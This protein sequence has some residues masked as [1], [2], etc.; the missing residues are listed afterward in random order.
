MGMYHSPNLLILS[1]CSAPVP[2]VGSR[3]KREQKTPGAGDAAPRG[4]KTDLL[5]KSVKSSLNQARVLSSL[6]WGKH[7]ECLHLSLTYG[8]CWP[9]TKAALASEKSLLTMALGRKVECGMWCLEYQQRG[10]P[11]FHVL[12]WLNGRSLGEFTAW[13]A[14][15]W[16]CVSDNRSS[17]GV[18][19]TSG[20]QARGVWYLAMHAA[21]R[22]Q[23]P[24]YAV[25]RWWGYIQRKRLF[26]AQDVHRVADVEERERIWWAR[27]YR[28]ATGCKVRQSQGFSWFLPRAWQCECWRWVRE[29]VAAE[30]IARGAAA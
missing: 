11:H 3:Q 29:Q 20:D 7:G 10:A 17:F 26:A 16:A 19:V 9:A 2:G 12:V 24:G 30:R 27:L 21:K 8:R 25:G 23:S 5:G 13:L 15:W 14:Q 6:D 4:T 18:K 22:A 1:R 28:R